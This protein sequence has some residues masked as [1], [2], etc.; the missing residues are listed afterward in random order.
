MALRINRLFIDMNSPLCACCPLPFFTI[1]HFW[2]SGKGDTF[3]CMEVPGALWL[4][5]RCVVF[6][7][8]SYGRLVSSCKEEWRQGNKCKS[9]CA[10]PNLLW[11]CPGRHFRF[12]L[13][14]LCTTWTL[15]CA[16]FMFF[17]SHVC[18]SGKGLWRAE[19]SEFG[20]VVR[21]VEGRVLLSSLQFLA[22]A[23]VKIVSPGTPRSG[24][25]LWGEWYC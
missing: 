2:A 16:T 12:N 3:A 11:L 7:E 15:C 6:I 17:F 24:P 8:L 4:P 9:T 25:V 5:G 23:S 19:L 10:F 22:M 14:S 18:F 21:M 13:W 1:P 20:S